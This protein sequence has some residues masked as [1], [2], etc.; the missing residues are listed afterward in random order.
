MWP[1]PIG[2][3]IALLGLASVLVFQP[4][5][6]QLSCALVG[7]KVPRF[8]AA[9]ATVVAGVV[10]G[11]LV[12]GLWSVTGGLILAQISGALAMASGMLISLMACAVVYSASLRVGMKQ[13]VGVAVVSHLVSMA[14]FAG[15]FATFLPQNI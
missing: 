3:Y 12:G 14:L 10:A 4:L 8:L 15:A 7:V 5:I 11:V 6:Y 2:L 1:H 13:A 9:V